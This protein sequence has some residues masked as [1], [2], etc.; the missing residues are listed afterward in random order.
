M[1]R[2]L[3]Q[4]LAIKIVIAATLF[5]TSINEVYHRYQFIRFC[6]CVL[7]GWLAYSCLKNAKKTDGIIYILLA[8][9]FNPFQK[10]PFD[11]RDWIFVN[12]CV[13]VF[14]AIWIA[15]EFLTFKRN[16]QGNIQSK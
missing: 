2:L 15:F 3:L 11:N 10:I 5:A 7:F 14:L 1:N 6:S 8:L 13:A 9:V 4:A 16:N 12:Q